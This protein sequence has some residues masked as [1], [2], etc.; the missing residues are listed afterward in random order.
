M[1]DPVLCIRCNKPITG[2][3]SIKRGYGGKC[4][5]IHRKESKEAPPTPDRITVLEQEIMKLKQEVTILKTSTRTPLATSQLHDLKTPSVIIPRTNGQ[6][7]LGISVMSGGWDVRELETNE[8]FQK[9]K[10]ECE[11]A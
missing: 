7:T 5:R 11:D 10:K 3:V 2:E 9:M 1:D 6:S 8:L 4:W